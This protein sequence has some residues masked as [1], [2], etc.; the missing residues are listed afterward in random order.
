MGSEFNGIA[1]YDSVIAIAVGD[2]L[3]MS[4]WLEA[5]D[6]IVEVAGG[7]D[8]GCLS[9]V[10]HIDNGDLEVGRI[11]QTARK[12]PRHQGRSPN[13]IVD[14]YTHDVSA[15][16]STF[17]RD[18]EAETAIAVAVYTDGTAR[19]GSVDHRGHASGI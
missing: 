12:S 4:A 8:E 1:Q 2:S 14:I 13:N 17:A 9:R 18:I 3:I 7:I 5:A 15:E 19:E 11:G 16:R 10:V 6:E